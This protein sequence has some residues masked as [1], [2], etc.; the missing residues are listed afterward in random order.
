MTKERLNVGI[1][2]FGMIGKV[3]SFCYAA[4]PYYA[5]ELAVTGRITHVATAHAE[6]ARTAGKIIG[7]DV[8]TTDFR[9]IT[10]NPEI[11][12]VH[13]CSPNDQHFPQL[14]SAIEH[15]K[16][17]YCDKPLT[18]TLEEAEQLE[19]AFNRRD[20][21]GKRL[22]TATF[23]MTFHLRFFAA[24][25]RARQLITENRLGRIFRFQMGYYHSSSASPNAPFR[26]K[27]DLNGGVIRDLVSHLLD[28]IDSLIGMPQ[29]FLTETAIGYPTRPV[30]PLRPGESI[31][32]VPG[33][34]VLS[35]ESVIILT[36]GHD[37]AGNKINGSIEA[38]RLATGHEDD[39]RLEI[40]GEKGALRFSLM[41]PHYLEF[42]DA[43]NSEHPY[44]GNSGW[45]KIA[46]GGRYELPDSEFPSAK[47]TT[48]WVRAHIASLSN[49]WQAIAGGEPGQP[50]LEQG[51]RIQRGLDAAMRSGQSGKW[52]SF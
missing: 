1:I 25:R 21:Q 18:A 36:R 34:P 33:R 40:N 23:Q 20:P 35:E 28:L 52:E 44:G 22:Y 39:F 48:G 47:A 17:I 13:I 32:D 2:G 7:C 26:W 19:A 49:F 31:S 10:E 6:T 4:L 5:P 37:T 9:E 38:T 14:L 15:N 8:G 51:V 27:H 29:E 50:G 3:H 46:V 24:I 30:R 16:H 11:D 12:V 45:Q 43:S 41:D 42:F